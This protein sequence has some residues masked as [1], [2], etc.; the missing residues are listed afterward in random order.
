MTGTLAARMVLTIVGSAGLI[1]GAFLKWFAEAEARGT[2]I[3]IRVLWTFELPEETSFVTSVGFVAIVLGL[4]ALVGLAFRTGWL[5]RVSGALG[6]VLF[7][8]LVITVYRVPTELAGRDLSLG[9]IGLGA[10]IVLAGGILALIGG[11]LGTRTVVTRPA[12]AAPPPAV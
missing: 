6:I 3:N 11:F 9:D 8:L 1:I 4:L 7:V 12:T 10:W 2:E 5:T